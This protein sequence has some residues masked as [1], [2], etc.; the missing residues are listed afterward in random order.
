[1]KRAGGEAGGRGS[2][3]STRRK[4]WRGSP[5]PP[6]QSLVPRGRGAS[7]H[8]PHPTPPPLRAGHS[9]LATV[10]ITLA[11]TAGRRSQALAQTASESQP[12]MASTPCMLGGGGIGQRAAPLERWGGHAMHM[13]MQC[14]PPHAWGAGM[15]A[16][17]PSQGCRQ[18][19]GGRSR[20]AHAHDHV[21]SGGGAC[22]GGTHGGLPAGGLRL[23]PAVSP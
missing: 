19:R 12:C 7:S 17:V 13:H 21:A 3:G 6:A 4:P 15:P 16:P 18:H 1:M 10:I 9:C 2:G 22:V 20:Q 23:L 8:C 5:G 14:V 11:C